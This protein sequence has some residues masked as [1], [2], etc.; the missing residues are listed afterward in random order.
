[1]LSVEKPS[2]RLEEVRGVPHVGRESSILSSDAVDLK[3][4][5]DGN[6]ELLE[7]P[8]EARDRGPA[9]ALSVD[10][11]PAGERLAHDF[12][13]DRA[14]PILER[15]REKAPPPELEGELSHAFGRVIPGVAPAEEADDQAGVVREGPAC[16]YILQADAAAAANDDEH[17]DGEA[18]ISEA[19]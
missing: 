11:E 17:R 2:V 14:A 5:L 8:R 4:E 16:L 18:D 15:L 10:D 1:M 13:S 3:R 9:E 7:L 6:G 19:H 12:E